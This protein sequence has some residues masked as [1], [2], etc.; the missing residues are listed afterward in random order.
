[1]ISINELYLAAA[2]LA[3]GATLEDIDRTNLRRQKFLFS[4][5]PVKEIWILAGHSILRIENPD[6]ETIK[7]K[8]TAGVLVFPPNFVDSV[9]KIKSAIYD[10]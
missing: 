2:L 10:V 7:T 3:Y 4:D 9:R 8:F 5:S 6:I 1:M